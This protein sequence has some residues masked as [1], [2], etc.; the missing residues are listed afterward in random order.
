[1]ET[2]RIT[3]IVKLANR[4]RQEIS[5]PVSTERLKQLQDSVNHSMQTI[6]RLLAEEGYNAD[7]LPA[8]SRAAYQFLLSLDFDSIA[9]EDNAHISN[10]P[11]GRISFRGLRNCF[12]G[13]LDRLASM[14][15]TNQSRDIYEYICSTSK[16]IENQ[17]HVDC[18]TLAQLT[19]ESREIRGW[20]AYFAQRQHFDVYQMAIR[21]VCPIF[22][23]ALQSIGKSSGKVLVHFQPMKGIYRIR[24]YPNLTLVQLPT[25]MICFDQETFQVLAAVAIL[26]KHSKKPLLEIM[27]SES[28]QKVLSEIELLGGV[29][30]NS[31]GIFYDLN[32]SFERINATYF[33]DK[34]PRPRLV[35]SQTFTFRKFGHY[36]NTHDTVM[37]SSS[38]DH[39]DTPE[40]VVDFI[41][42]HE[43]LHKK[44]G[45]IWSNGRQSIH[46]QDFQKEERRFPRYKEA[47]AFL[48]KLA[49]SSRRNQIHSRLDRK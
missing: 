35:W 42:Y 16:N 33:E 29:T 4:V 46:T 3:G 1:M 17:I 7:A 23:K 22:T 28:Y 48:K 2:I 43:L 5:S 8:P 47:C 39:K 14:D 11:P 45:V 36:D 10:Q 40:Y 12:K 32:K 13:I 19:T 41:M 9:T 20:L 34:M 31:I 38:L 27:E 37:V 21:Q 26:K 30:E 44:L 25:P 18:I 24:G 6:D 15:E 49:T